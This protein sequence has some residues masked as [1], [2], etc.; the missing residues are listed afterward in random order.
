MVWKDCSVVEKL[1][2]L[3][4]DPSSI[5]STHIIFY[6]AK[7]WGSNP[8]FWIPEAHYMHMVY[9]Q[10]YVQNVLT[11]K[12]KIKGNSKIGKNAK[13]GKIHNTVK[14]RRKLKLN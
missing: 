4:E 2:A 5:S 3:P 7:P 10:T 12:I 11:H 1:P 6:N 9:R 8:L 14:N 13:V